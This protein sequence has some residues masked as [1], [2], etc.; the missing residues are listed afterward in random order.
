MTY[1]S[2]IQ[3]FPLLTEDATPTKQELIQA[4]LR[5][6]ASIVNKQYSSNHPLFDDL[7]QIG[8]I[9]LMDSANSYDPS[10]GPSFTSY[11]IPWIKMAVMNYAIDNK[12]PIRMLTNKPVRKAYFNRSKYMT[13]NGLDRER[14]ASELGITIDNIREMEQRTNV[15]YTPV[16]NENEDETNWLQ[17]PDNSNNPVSMIAEL[18]FER[19]MQTDLVAAINKLNDRE[20]FIINNRYYVEQPLVY[21]DIAAIFGVSIERVRQIEREACIKLERS[22]SYGYEMCKLEM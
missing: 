17:I 9:A 6:V 16:V 11:A 3:Q 15:Q 22:L 12:Y 5:L 2:Q 8:N 14:M 21:K 20:Q 13:D 18:E 10:Q 4:H 19:F 7:I 1:I